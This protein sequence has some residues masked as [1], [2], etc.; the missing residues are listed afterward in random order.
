[1]FFISGRP[2]LTTIFKEVVIVINVHF[3]HRGDKIDFLSWLKRL[4]LFLS[5]NTHLISCFQN[6]RILMMGDFNN[7][8]KDKINLQFIVKQKNIKFIR[9][10]HQHP[11]AKETKTCCVDKKK[12]RNAFSIDQIFDSNDSPLLTSILNTK[13]NPSSDHYPVCSLLI[14]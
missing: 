9:K 14:E 13:H 4:N 12:K 6:F 3:S 11:N 8:L 2:V 5:K 7:E 1:M 10:L